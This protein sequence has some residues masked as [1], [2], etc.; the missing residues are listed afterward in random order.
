[1]KAPLLPLLLLLAC[2][3]C[4]RAP[5]AQVDD[6]PLTPLPV[7]KPSPLLVLMISGDGGWAGLDQELAAQF[8]ERGLPVVGVSSLKYFWKLRTPD[9]TAA[10]I[11]RALHHY[12]AEWKTA[13]IL[14]VGYSFGADV[15]PFVYNRLPADLK[16]RVTGIALLAVSDRADFEV[17][18]ADWVGAEGEGGLD[19][20][21]ELARIAHLPV[22]CLWGEGDDVAEKG[23]AQSA[24]PQRK[25]LSIGDG[26]HFGYLH[27][28]LATQILAYA[29]H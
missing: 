17:H 5:P 19:V 22:L 13:K 21:P 2:A 11:T 12:V 6:L 26:H 4:S 3:A 20:G 15:M 25:T 8:N 23:C 10:D 29:G 24:G 7:A 18:V 1:M 27:S 9:E 28:E 14:L 16:S